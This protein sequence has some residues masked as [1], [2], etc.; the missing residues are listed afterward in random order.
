MF[1]RRIAF[2]VD[3]NTGMVYSRVGERVAVPV[4]VEGGIRVRGAKPHYELESFP[5]Y[6][7]RE[8]WANLL[9]TQ[10]VPIHIQNYHR[11]FWRLPKLT[12]T[13]SE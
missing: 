8:R 6:A 9:S 3:R 7:I 4:R 11:E 5:V 13:S 10:R 1:G 12:S 2:A